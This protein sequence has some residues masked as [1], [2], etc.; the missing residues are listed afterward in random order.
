[1]DAEDYDTLIF[2]ESSKICKQFFISHALQQKAQSTSRGGA[3]G[4]EGVS[5]EKQGNLL[6]SCFF[7]L[8]KIINNFYTF[9]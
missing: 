3:R 1:M 6:I 4:G 2:F 9:S 5:K 8:A 7:I